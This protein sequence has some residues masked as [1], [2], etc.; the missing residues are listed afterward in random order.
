MKLLRF[1]WVLLALM[2]L[3]SIASAHIQVD[4][5][6]VRA[7]VPGQQATGAFMKITST[8][9]VK[10]VSVATPAANI[11]EIHETKMENGVM[12]MRAHLEG[13]DI[14]AKK[15]VELKPGGHHLMMMDLTQTIKTGGVV[16]LELQFVDAKGRKDTVSVNAKTSFKDPYQK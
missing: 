8:V 9:P 2:G 1:R 3:A 13:L 15:T 7:T 6:W 12:K 4:N 11:N 5:A 14:P 16:A 10:L